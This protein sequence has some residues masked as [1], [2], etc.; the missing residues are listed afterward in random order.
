MAG[1]STSSTRSEDLR[2]ASVRA[3]PSC[4][5]VAISAAAFRQ[6]SGQHALERAALFRRLL[7]V[8]RFPG[9][10]C[11]PAVPRR[12]HAMRPGYIAARRTAPCGQPRRLR[13]PSTSLWPSG[14]PWV[15]P[16]PAL[17]GAP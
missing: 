10:A 3:A 7:G 4:L 1:F 17:V 8:L 11:L 2:L 15:F 6:F 5:C 13:A 12:F 16:L 9:L 14:L